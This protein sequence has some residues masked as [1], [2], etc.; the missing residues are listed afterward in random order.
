MLIKVGNLLPPDTLFP[1][2]KVPA[3]AEAYPDRRADQTASGFD[4][5]SVSMVNET[6]TNAFNNYILLY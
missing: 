4:K 2:Q 1:V 5:S 6:P 3:D